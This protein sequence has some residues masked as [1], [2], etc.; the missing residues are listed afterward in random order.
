MLNDNESSGSDTMGMM[1]LRE[2]EMIRRIQPCPRNLP[3]KMNT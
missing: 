2:T 1:V 3:L